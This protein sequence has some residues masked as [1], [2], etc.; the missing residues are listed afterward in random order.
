MA[1]LGP[2]VIQVLEFASVRAPE[3]QALHEIAHHD[4]MHTAADAKLDSQRNQRRRRAN[5]FKSHRMPQRLRQKESRTDQSRQE[6]ELIS[7]KLGSKQA[8]A[9]A[10]KNAGVVQSAVG[11]KAPQQRCRKH[12][13]R[14]HKLVK[15]RSW[16]QRNSTID[17]LETTAVWM[18][19]H[20]WHTKRMKMVEK[21]G[22]MLPA[23]RADK[24]M[25]ASLDLILEALQLVSD[26]AGSDFHGMRF[27]SGSEEG[28]SILYHEG[29]FPRGAICPVTFMWRPLQ[30]DSRVS[31]SAEDSRFQLHADWQETKRQL[32]LW[33]HPAAFME[34]ASAIKAACEEVMDDGDD[35]QITDRRG[36]LCRFKL[37]GNIADEL[38]SQICGAKEK[39]SPIQSDGSISVMDETGSDHE[40][41]FTNSFTAKQCGTSN[42]SVLCKSLG[43]QQTAGEQLKV[44]TSTIHTVVVPDPRTSSQH[45]QSSDQQGLSLLREP[46]PDELSKQAD[47]I[48][49]P[50]SEQNL[51]LQNAA[52]EPESALILEKLSEILQWTSTPTPSE[53]S[54]SGYPFTSPLAKETPRDDDADMEAANSN[55]ASIPCSFL[56]SVSKRLQLSRMF[57]KD[58]KVNS[59]KYQARQARVQQMAQGTA[60]GGELSSLNESPNLHLLVIRKNE[61]FPKASG[62]DLI[63]L[64]CF[65]ATLLKTLVFAGAFVVG[66][67]EDEALDT[68]LHK[69]SF[70]RDFPGTHA[71]ERYWNEHASALESD[72]LK[73][74][75]AKRFA[76]AKHGIVSPF[77]PK[78]TLL[79]T[80][81]DSTDAEAEGEKMYD[82]DDDDDGNSSPCVLRGEGY[83]EPFCFYS[84][85][86][87]S[88]EATQE[89]I[90][91]AVPTLVRVILR[92]PGR[93]SLV[94]NAMMYVPTDEDVKNF[95]TQKKWNGCEITNFASP[96]RTLVGF[97]TSAVYDRPKG[98][99]RATG[100]C[101]CESL[102]EIF[103]QQREF[104]KSQDALV[105]LR[106]PQAKLLRPVLIRVE[107]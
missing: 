9:V 35:I 45:G 88:A 76:Y 53:L 103:L 7:L 85:P 31:E 25:S 82:D 6:E 89:K 81:G 19:T 106:I 12:E 49:C 11:V 95:Y 64:P 77:Q 73:K 55:D 104:M 65:A 94:P 92:V 2:R 63:V 99:F 13:R 90:P 20:V 52:E 44:A 39:R 38:V 5:A 1:T 57:E 47:G 16:Q 36:H 18:A 15:S 48:V 23:H 97:V 33:I 28:Q 80:N 54:P 61:P 78:W 37:R 42:L 29:Q 105:M 71:G 3:L 86:N 56:W 66:V 100:F 46:S 4:Q 59:K 58:H 93:A 101:D 75:I 74:P 24:S 62:W 40:D 84:K 41:G 96:E 27:L 83:M 32:W 30:S 70:P 67:D 17:P 51:T 60:G 50:V 91:V 102:Q 87:A 8:S 68:V 26:P 69:A 21:Y 22:M 34:A 43:K 10:D 98:A 14:P 72:Y 107:M 79:F